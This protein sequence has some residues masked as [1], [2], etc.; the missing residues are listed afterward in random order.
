MFPRLS[1]VL[2]LL[3]FLT[4]ARAEPGSFSE[5]WQTFTGCTLIANE[6]ND[7]DSFHVRAQGREFIFRLYFVDAPEVHDVSPGKSR[8][9]EQAR[10]WKISKQTLAGLADEATSFS[11]AVLSAAP[12]TV[13]TRWEDARGESRLPREFAI[14]QTPRGDLAELLV[15]KGL[16]RIHGHYLDYPRGPAAAAYQA[17]LK[18]LE[19]RARSARLG[20]WSGS[21]GPSAAPE[22]VEPAAAEEG[23]ATSDLPGF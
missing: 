8:T 17:R 10:Y 7:G 22:S 14:I 3:A 16:A 5:K 19:A 1:G 23:T 15:S 11:R 18:S 21:A 12:F 2:A 4:A 9:T 20:G 13:L 6:W